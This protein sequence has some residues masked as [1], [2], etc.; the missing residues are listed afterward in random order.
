M[1][2]GGGAAGNTAICPILAMDGMSYTRVSQVTFTKTTSF[3]PFTFCRLGSGVS[4]CTTHMEPVTPFAKQI[5]TDRWFGVLA[6]LRSASSVYILHYYRTSTIGNFIC[7]THSI[8]SFF[9]SDPCPAASTTLRQA[10]RIL[11]GTA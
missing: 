1:Y 8:D 5:V 3:P 11:L 10:T 4:L 6:S 9:T 2:L 7:V